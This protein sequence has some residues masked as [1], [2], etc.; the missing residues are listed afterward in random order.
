[1]RPVN[2]P[3][4]SR[5]TR[6]AALTAG[7]A[8]AL[9]LLAACGSSGSGSSTTT[10]GGATTTTVVKTTSLDGVKVSDTM[11]TKPTISFDPSYVGTGP[12]AKVVV[13]GTGAPVTEGQRVTTQYVLVSGADGTELDSSWSRG[14][15]TFT[16][17]SKSLLPGIYDNL[18]NQ[19]LGSRILIATPAQDGSGTW[20]LFVFDLQ[21]A[22]T[23]PTEASG[24]AVTPPAGLPTVTFTNG[25]PTIS[26]PNT[27]PPT[28]LVVQPLI[29]G[30]G[31]AVTA[32]QTV[33]LNYA[34]FLWDGGTQFDS[35][36]D[37]GTPV[38]FP[39]GSNQVIPGF[40][41]GIV[42]QTVGSR[43]LLVIPPDKGY[44]E[45]G[46]TQ[47]SIPPNATLVFVV[48]ILAAG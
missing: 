17:N 10:T 26:V 36:W 42:G 22:Q 8:A 37:R 29:K 5:R 24:Q 43:V 4:R 19:P 18:V 40:D 16:L 21:S 14:A 28:D 39:I 6:L 46:N 23:I 33:T 20:L 31:P 15:Q 1:M 7:L 32:G 35:S 38:D 41:S 45:Q 11:G 27:P 13:K 44:G 12:A 25:K 3:H 30:T 9:L 48:D 2:L 47:A 34:G